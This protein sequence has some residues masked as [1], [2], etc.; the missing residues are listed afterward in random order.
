[1]FTL[2]MRFMVRGSGDHRDD[3]GLNKFQKLISRIAAPIAVRGDGDATMMTRFTAA[4][5]WFF[6]HHPTRLTR[7]YI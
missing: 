2:L 4:T 3:P 6:N 5:H 7:T 1:M